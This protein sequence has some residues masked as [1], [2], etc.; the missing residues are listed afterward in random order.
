MMMPIPI[1]RPTR[2]SDSYGLPAKLLHFLLALVVLATIGL[3]FAPLLPAP[4]RATARGWHHAL[5]IATWILTLLLLVWRRYGET[6]AA[7]SSHFDW[8]VG[9][10]RAMHALL[11]ALLVLLPPAGYL[12]A[13]SEGPWV[14][15]FRATFVPSLSLPEAGAVWMRQAHGALGWAMVATLAVHL[16]IALFHHLVLRDRTLR[17]IYGR[18]TA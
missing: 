15:L 6:P 1:K 16:G 8:Q 3:A 18:R 12:A 14:R 10:A 11:Y 7:L 9:A 17:R 5:G 13:S 2:R 4:L